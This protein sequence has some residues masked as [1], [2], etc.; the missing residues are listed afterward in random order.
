MSVV[1][2]LSAVTKRD[3]VHDAT[4]NFKLPAAVKEVVEE[5]A[6]ERGVFPAVILREALADYLRPRV[7][8]GE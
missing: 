2:Q 8:N 3:K 4:M 1:D 7:G 6:K 5:L